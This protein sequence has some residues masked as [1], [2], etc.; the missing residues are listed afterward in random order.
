MYTTTFSYPQSQASPLQEGPSPDVVQ[1]ISLAAMAQY[2]VTVG[3]W[4]AEDNMSFRFTINGAYSGVCAAKGH[5]LR[6]FPVVVS[7]GHH[8]SRGSTA[9][10]TVDASHYPSPS[11]G[12]FGSRRV[13]ANL[14]TQRQEMV[15]RRR[16]S[17][18]C[19]HRRRQPFALA[20]HSLLVG[21]HMPHRHH[22]YISFSL[23]RQSAVVGHAGRVVR[24]ASRGR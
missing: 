17:N 20:V 24:V 18:L 2:S 3:F 14:E 22:R 11:L 13:G 12:D 9:N 1:R 8:P 5:I 6:E 10:L 15:G 23:N 16:F 7:S 21:G 4:A 19:P